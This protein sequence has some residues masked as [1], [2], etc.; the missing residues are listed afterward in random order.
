MINF[1]FNFEDIKVS[2]SI[3]SKIEE[4][5]EDITENEGVEYEGTVDVTFTDDSEIREINKTTRNIDKATDVLSFPLLG[6][7]EG[8]VFSENYDDDSLTDDLFYDDKLMLGD[9]V[10]SLETAKKQ[11]EEFGHSFERE[12]IFLFTH[13]LLH[14]LGY[15]HM[16][17]SDAE[18]MNE[19]E[20]F[21]LN[22]AGV[23]RE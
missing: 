6:Y 1:T 8:K 15:D 12:V 21:Y 19:K 7:P 2:D 9:V 20:E 17:E 14:L 10:I 18:R 23:T 22:R 4:I 16:N 11:S 5:F 3:I 13:S